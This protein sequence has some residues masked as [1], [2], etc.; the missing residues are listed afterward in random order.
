MVY[1]SND[2]YFGVGLG[3]TRYVRGL[4]ATNTRDLSTYLRCLEAGRPVIGPSE[5]LNSEARARETAVLMLRRT[6]LGIDR[7]DFVSR[8]GYE[9]D[10]LAGATLERHVAQHLLADDGQRVRFTL[11]GLFLADCVLCDLL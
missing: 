10:A 2:A 8:T 11:E 4:R 3:A 9:L 6:V 1:W 5:T 7:A